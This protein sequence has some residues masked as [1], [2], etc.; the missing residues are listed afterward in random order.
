MT[1]QTVCCYCGTTDGLRPYGP[2]GAAVCFD[3]GTS[4]EHNE[5]TSA[6]FIAQLEAAIA[7]SAGSAGT[8]PVILLGKNGPDVSSIEELLN[9]DV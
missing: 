4:P 8:L 1:D 3:C 9:G 7:M 2:G 5:E 6:N